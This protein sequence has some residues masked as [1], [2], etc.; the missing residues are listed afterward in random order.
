MAQGEFSGR[1][2]AAASGAAL[3]FMLSVSSYVNP[4]F[5]VFLV[6]LTHEFGW[7][8]LEISVTH[9]FQSWTMAF[10]FLFTGR[11]M[12][13]FGVRA[14]LLPGSALL[15]LTIASMSLQTGSIALL[16][17]QYTLVGVCGALGGM[18]AVAK[19]V[20][21]WFHHNRGILLSVMAVCGL[22]SSAIVP[23]FANFMI[24]HLG[25][26]QAY[27]GLGAF[28]LVIGLP[29]IALLIREQ[30]TMIAARTRQKRQEAHAKFGMTSAEACRT[31]AFVLCVAFAAL[32]IITNTAMLAHTIPMLTDR[33]IA[34]GTAVTV[35]SLAALGGACGHLVIGFL[36]DRV[37][38]PRLAI[39]FALLALCGVLLL[40]QG[41]GPLAYLTGGVLMGVGITADFAVIPYFLTRFFG[42]RA[43]AQIYGFLWSAAAIASGLGPPAMG[44]IFDWTGSYSWALVAVEINLLLIVACLALMPAYRFPARLSAFEETQAEAETQAGRLQPVAG[45]G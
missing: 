38:S 37:N 34:R 12:D 3:A 10:L 31:R 27:L 41:S 15:A 20:S 17:A 1:A 4:I 44:A 7:G 39:P 18:V 2:I 43:F 6:P 19:V 32:V 21:G 36:L 42:L 11:L 16:Y 30:P 25:W 8:R 33:G 28:M 24:E 5:G 40:H 13:R 29:V 26:R 23:Q 22:A 9:T 14:I 35:I 45:A